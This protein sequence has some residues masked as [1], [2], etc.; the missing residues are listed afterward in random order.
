MQIKLSKRRR[1]VNDHRSN[2]YIP[3]RPVCFIT[4][5]PKCNS[6]VERF[7]YL[8]QYVCELRAQED[9]NKLEAWNVFC[10]FRTFTTVISW[11][12][13]AELRFIIKGKSTTVPSCYKRTVVK[14]AR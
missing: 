5:V 13:K 3:H 10:V 6:S 2:S 9:C 12:Q 11:K 14:T 7:Y 4:I 1:C 8:T